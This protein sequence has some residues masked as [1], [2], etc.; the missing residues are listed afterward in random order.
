MLHL[1]ERF[2]QDNKDLKPK[3]RSWQLCVGVYAKEDSSADEKV[4]YSELLIKLADLAV[5]TWVIS[6]PECKLDINLVTLCNDSLAI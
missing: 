6:L 3:G 5:K 2:S 4:T 1:F